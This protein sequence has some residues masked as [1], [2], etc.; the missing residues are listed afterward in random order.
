M[1]YEDSS[2]KT[3]VLCQF[4]AT[5]STTMRICNAKLKLTGNSSVM[6][7]HLFNVHGL[8]IKDIDK[9]Y[10]K[11]DSAISEPQLSIKQAFSNALPY[12]QSSLKY[13][14]LLD[15]TT[16]FI[17]KA[18]QP[19]SR[20]N[21]KAFINLISA[22][23]SRFAL[24]TRQKLTKEKRGT[25]WPDPAGQMVRIADLLISHPRYESGNSYFK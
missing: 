5:T 3:H 8:N 19:L 1:K 15:A 16:N 17:F 20:V 25:N 22:L 14:L 24:P 21:G 4:K 6:S 2:T 18:N 23:D 9:N 7:S 12:C 13:Q 11:N 10:I